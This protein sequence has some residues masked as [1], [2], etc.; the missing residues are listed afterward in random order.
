[1]WILCIMVLGFYNIL[2]MSLAV[3]IMDVLGGPVK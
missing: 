1:M 2:E 3:D